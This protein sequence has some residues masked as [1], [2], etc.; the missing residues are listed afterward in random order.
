MAAES[1]SRKVKIIVKQPAPDKSFELILYSSQP[2]TDKWVLTQLRSKSLRDGLMQWQ[3]GFDPHQQHLITWH[4][5][6]GQKIQV[7]TRKV[8]VNLSGRSIQHQALL[9][10]RQKYMLNIRKGYV[11]VGS[12]E[13]PLIKI[14]RAEEYDQH[15]HK[16]NFPLSVETKL[17][18]IRLWVRKNHVVEGY[19]RG[20]KSFPHIDHILNECTNF[21]NYLPYNAAIDGEMFHHDLDFTIIT[22][23]ARTTKFR[24]PLM[25]MLEYY[26]FDVWWPDNPPYEQRRKVLEDAMALYRTENFPE[27]NYRD[28]RTEE[29]F[30]DGAEI[31]PSK[32]K[33]FL[34]E[35]HIV[36]SVDEIYEHHQDFVARGYEGTMIKKHSNG[37][38]IGT[39]EY[40]ASTYLFGKGTRILKLKDFIDEEATC[41]GV[42][43]SAGSEEGCAM[44]Q[45]E[46]I[47]GNQF[48]VRMRGPFERRRRWFQHPE[49]II[50]KQITFRYQTL[51]VY[52]VP[53]F[54]VGVEVRDYE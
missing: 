13:V 3:I 4:G 45:I 43:N 50:G 23:I 35:R 37:A 24:H 9:E 8:E 21:L 52:N 22:S 14:M 19:S 15:K 53:I 38:E 49:E 30:E 12:S 6:V 18:G 17:N 44:L 36:D 46:D 10:A 27:D 39:R 54:P 31:D 2:T 51:S 32:T 7:K 26:I 25:Y 1:S 5:G 42:K 11:P 33:L 29:E 28:T 41:I 16:L 40:T 48:Y 34:T 20:N 47:R